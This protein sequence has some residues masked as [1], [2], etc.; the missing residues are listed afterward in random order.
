MELKIGSCSEIAT[1]EFNEDALQ[2]DVSQ[3][4]TVCVVADGMGFDVT[5]AVSSRKAASVLCRMLNRNLRIGQN[6][7]V[8]R[9]TILNSLIQAHEELLI[10]PGS[11]GTTVVLAVWNGGPEMFVV[12]V[13]DSRAYLIRNSLI[14]QLTQDDSLALLAAGRR[15]VLWRYLG[16][17]DV[18][19]WPEVRAVPMEVEDRLLLCTDGLHGAVDDQELLRWIHEHPDPQRCAEALCQLALERGARDNISCIVIEVV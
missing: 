1:R 15:A 11:S 5:E 12:G 14:E 9:A 17:R 13:G 16:C 7:D 6:R 10:L 2:I 4:A 18:Q 3:T 19:Q 8:V